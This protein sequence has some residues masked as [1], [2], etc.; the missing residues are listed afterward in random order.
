MIE[1]LERSCG[2]PLQKRY[3][4][5]VIELA[6]SFELVNS[7]NQFVISTVPGVIIPQK[8][9]IFTVTSCY[10]L[11]WIEQEQQNDNFLSSKNLNVCFTREC[12]EGKS[13]S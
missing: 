9:E 2:L 13:D 12:M 3:L 5:N 4:G 1:K 7:K 10:E 6:Q 8:T 11:R